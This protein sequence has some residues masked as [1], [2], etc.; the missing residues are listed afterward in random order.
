MDGKR[1]I[2]KRTPISEIP[3]D[4]DVV[5]LGYGRVT[6]LIMGQSP[7]SSTYNKEGVGSPLFLRG[8]RK[9][10]LEGSP[11]PPRKLSIL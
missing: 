1:M 11:K 4:W 5:E 10:L 3:E 8:R 6:E 2:C 7:P 9:K